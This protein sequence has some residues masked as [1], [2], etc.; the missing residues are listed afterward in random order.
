MN[1]M[2]EM[3]ER[4][5]I[6]CADIAPG[7]ESIKA[8]AAS[9]QASGQKPAKKLPKKITETYLYNAGLYY[10]QRY[11]AS[12]TR[13][14]TVMSR[15]IDLSCRHYPEQNRDDSLRLLDQLITKFQDLGYLNDDNYTRMKVTS[16]CRRG[17]SRRMMILKLQNAGIPEERITAA[18]NEFA[19]ENETTAQETEH[20]AALKLARKKRVGP[21]AEGKPYD[22]NKAMAAFARAGF[23]FDVVRNILDM[24]Q[25]TPEDPFQEPG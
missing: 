1:E 10:L 4:P 19:A 8:D 22:R 2:N 17:I 23:S 18:L 25:D 9:G 21:Y 11:A 24:D 15:K 16:L 12:S 20:A 14:R 6:A 3:N 13:F 5:K 7:H